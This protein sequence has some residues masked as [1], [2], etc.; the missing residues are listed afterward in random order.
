MTAIAW[1]ALHRLIELDLDE[2]MIGPE[3]LVRRY[4]R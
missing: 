2:C 1:M 3:T 4:R